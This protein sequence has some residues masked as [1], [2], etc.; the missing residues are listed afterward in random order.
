M[1]KCLVN[2]SSVAARL[3][4]A[5]GLKA[6]A[7]RATATAAAVLATTRTSGSLR[8]RAKEGV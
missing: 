8:D 5:A 4:T 2:S 1:T 3:A 6:W 7:L